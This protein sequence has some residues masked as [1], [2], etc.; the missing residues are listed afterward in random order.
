MNE[1]GQPER[2]NPKTFPA[3][4]YKNCANDC[5]CNL[6]KHIYPTPGSHNT[7]TTPSPTLSWIERRQ[8]EVFIDEG[9]GVKW[10]N[11]LNPCISLFLAST[12]GRRLDHAGR[13]VNLPPIVP[14]IVDSGMC[15]RA[16]P[17]QSQEQTWTSEP[18]RAC[19]CAVRIAAWSTH[20]SVRPVLFLRLRRAAH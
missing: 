4:K 2:G 1:F 16:A 17:R 20:A 10:Y 11:Q 19:P 3:L 15:Y 6:H 9:Q 7:E 5:M 8:F 18:V 12:K 13:T 14:R